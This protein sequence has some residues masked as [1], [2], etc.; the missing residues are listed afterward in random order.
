VRLY[1]KLFLFVAVFACLASRRVCQTASD[2][3]FDARVA[4]VCRFG[5]EADLEALIDD[6]DH[7]LA[8]AADNLWVYRAG[9]RYRQLLAEAHA[10]AARLHTELTDADRT[11]IAAEAFGKV[12]GAAVDDVEEP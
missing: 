7:M 3:A 6:T 11:R 10:D 5:S 1:L 9:K 8:R 12:E 2:L 4:F